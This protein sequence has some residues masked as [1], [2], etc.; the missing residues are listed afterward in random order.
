VLPFLLSRNSVACDRSSWRVARPTRDCGASR[1]LLVPD[2]NVHPFRTCLP[3]GL[4][5]A[6]APGTVAAQE[7]SGNPRRK[8]DGGHSRQERGLV[9]P[10]YDRH[11]ECRSGPKWHGSPLRLHRLQSTFRRISV[12]VAR[13]SKKKMAVGSEST[14]CWKGG[15]V[16][17]SRDSGK[18]EAGSGFSD[19]RAGLGTWRQNTPRLGVASRTGVP[20]AASSVPVRKVP[21]VSRPFPLCRRRWI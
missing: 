16:C 15:G 8:G 1:R 3:V 5:A 19:S 2:W 20:I 21:S 17:G 6:N 4:R 14:Q 11:Y 9:R 10:T 7:L 13:N 12:R 18:D